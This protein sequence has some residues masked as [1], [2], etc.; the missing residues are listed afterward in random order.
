MLTFLKFSALIVTATA[1]FVCWNIFCAQTLVKVNGGIQTA[2][3]ATYPGNH[4]SLLL[5]HGKEWMEF[6][7]GDWD[8]YGNSKVTFW[9]GFKSMGIRTQGAIGT[10]T[11]KWDG[12]DPGRFVEMYNMVNVLLINVDE[13]NADQLH[14]RLSK[15]VANNSGQGVFNPDNKLF[16]VKH[17]ARYAAW[18]TCNNML[19]KWLLELGLEINGSGWA[20]NF[21]VMPVNA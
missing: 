2:Y 3:I 1:L 16:F 9:T 20:G 8:V 14:S 6:S 10:R 11:I 19:I 18:H 7:Y 17:P 13:K 4:N 21:K 15:W 12:N 5:Q